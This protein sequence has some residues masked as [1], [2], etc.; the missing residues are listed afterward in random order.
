MDYLTKVKSDLE[1]ACNLPDW[2]PK[3]LSLG[4][5]PLAVSVAYDWLYYDLSLNE[6]ELI[7]QALVEKGIK[8]VLNKDMSTSI[9]NW[10]SVTLGGATMAS[11][12]LYEK[13]KK[14]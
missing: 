11:L 2:D 7:H 10:N 14:L 6:R 8:P 9:G 3:G 12:A 13:E 1:K 5:I 4:E